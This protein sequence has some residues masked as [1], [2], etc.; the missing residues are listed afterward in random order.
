M[1]TTLTTKAITV[2]KL[3]LGDKVWLHNRRWTLVGMQV[4]EYGV[5]AG[6][7][8]NLR[9]IEGNQRVEFFCDFDVV[10]IEL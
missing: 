3:E 8:L 7:E 6:R 5:L 4:E 10:T 9:D 1:A 2:D